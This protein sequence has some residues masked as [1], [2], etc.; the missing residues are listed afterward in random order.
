MKIRKL[1]LK[2]APFM[3]EWM[4]DCEIVQYMHTNFSKKTLDDCKNFIIKSKNDEKNFHFAIVNDND[5]YMGTVSLKCINY[6]DKSA[7][8]GITVRRSAM[9]NGY[10]WYGMFSILKYAFETLDLSYVYW[11]V[12]R[13]NARAVRFYDKHHFS[14]FADVPS[15]AL[16]RYL[17]EPNVKW[18]IAK[19]DM[20]L[21]MS[22]RNTIL[23]CKI[24]KIK[25]ID[26][27]GSGQLSFFEGEKSLPFAIKRIYYISKVPEGKRR[28]F[29]AHKELKQLLFCPYGEI[30]I[31]LDDG[32]NREEILLND[33]STG[34]VIEKP[35]W[36][37][38]VWI[39][40][41]SVLCVAASDYYSEDDYIRS[42]DDF[43]TYLREVNDK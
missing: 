32:I 29:H 38:M 25:T 20:L 13:N 9:G 34:I 37:E 41:D 43:K 12:P 6:L 3:L 21:S 7:E 24:I 23:G 10:S 22:R 18:Y 40:T 17:H 11:C 28:G 2:D 27:T 35:I 8:F 4:H 15:E 1:K 33:P 14:D 19:K 31:I 16:E 26:T 36:R 39:K 5:E 30:S 42:Y